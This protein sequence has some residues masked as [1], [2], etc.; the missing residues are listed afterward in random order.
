M[1]TIII[2]STT[3]PYVEWNSVR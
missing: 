2:T 3:T 1:T